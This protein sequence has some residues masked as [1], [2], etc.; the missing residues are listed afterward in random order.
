MRIIILLLLVIFTLQ[1]CNKNEAK[2]RDENLKLNDELSILKSQIDSLGNLPTIQ[3]EKLISE[4]FSLDALRKKNFSEYV[5]YLKNNELKTKDS[6]LIEKYL[7]FAKQNKESFYSMY[8]IDRIRGINFQKQQLNISQ[9]V[10]KWQWET[11]TNLLQPFKGSKDEQILFQKDK[12]LKIFNNGKLVSNGK[13]ELI[14]QGWG[15]YYIEFECNKLYSIQVKQNGLLTL[16]KGKGF[17][18]DCGTDVYR[19]VE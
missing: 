8:A 7:T 10:G 12:T 3:F 6:I 18:I 13:F 19:K 9:I 14:R 16:T 4:D 17:C 15:N 11:M 5:S 1:S 2:L